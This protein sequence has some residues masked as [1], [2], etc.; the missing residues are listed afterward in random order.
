[1][2]GLG[3]GQGCFVEPGLKYGGAARLEGDEFQPHSGLRVRVSHHASSRKDLPLIGDLNADDS[4]RRQRAAGIQKT[5]VG[6]EVACLGRGW[7]GRS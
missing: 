2:V 5:T 7:G 1:M 3:L 4:A 6:A